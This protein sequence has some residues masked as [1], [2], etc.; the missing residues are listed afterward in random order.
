MRATNRPVPGTEFS[1]R[2]SLKVMVRV[3]PFIC[4][5]SIPGGVVSPVVLLVTGWAA[6]SGTGFFALSA[7][8]SGLL[9]G[10]V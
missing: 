5:L 8:R 2:R 9:S 10:A 4:T 7:S 6:K 1:S 3:A